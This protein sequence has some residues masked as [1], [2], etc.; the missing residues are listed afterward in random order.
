MA[1]Y[2][3]N[4]RSEAPLDLRPG[5]SYDIPA[6]DEVDGTPNDHGGHVAHV[7]TVEEIHQKK[8]SVLCSCGEEWRWTLNLEDFTTHMDPPDE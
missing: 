5:D 2:K 8:H 3:V 6:Y 7:R 4:D 1:H